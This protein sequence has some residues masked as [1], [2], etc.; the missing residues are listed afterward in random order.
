MGK[1]HEKTSIRW[2]YFIRNRKPAR[3][4]GGEVNA[5]MK[6]VEDIDVRFACVSRMSMR[7]VCLIWG[8]RFFMICLT[9]ERMC[10]VRGLLSINDLDK[11]MKLPKIPL[12]SG[13]PDPIKDFDFLGITIQFEMCYTNIL[14]IADLK[15]RFHCHKGQNFRW[16]ICDWR[17]PVHIQSGADRRVLWYLL[18]RRRWDGLWWLLD[19]YKEWK[20]SEKVPGVL[21]TCGADR[22]SVCFR[23]YD[24]EYNED[25][26]LKSFTPNNEYASS[27]GF[28][29][30][31]LWM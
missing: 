23:F 1:I 20:G 6:N 15:V 5:V 27:Y 4:I 19:T 29:K 9:A 8:F 30:Q 14:Q 12:F 31:L 24:A 25:G 10:G 13:V 17:W 22:G 3:Y 28:K 7:S 21:R 16:S 26:T 2:W 18:Y 11:V